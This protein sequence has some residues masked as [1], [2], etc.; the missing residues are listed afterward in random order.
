M[1]DPI[2]TLLD[3]A[4]W[5]AESTPAAEHVE[6][7]SEPEP[8][9]EE[10]EEVEAGP[11]Q[12]EGE[13]AEDED[14]E[15]GEDESEEEGDESEPEAEDVV[16]EG[17]PEVQAFLSKYGND[18]QKA[19]KG[20]AELSRLLG[21]QGRDLSRAQTENEQLRAAL[22]ESQA[23]HA[24]LGMPLNEQQREWVEGAAASPNPA[25]FVQ[26][27]VNEG[28]FDLARAVCREWAVA[29]PYDAL[30]VGQWVNARQDE[31]YRAANQAPQATTDQ[32][33]AALD[34]AM[35]EMRPFYG[36]MTHVIAQ[37]GD[38]HPLVQQSRSPDAEEAMAGMI[39]LYEIARA[40]TATIE[41]AQDE[42]KKKRRREA[43]DERARGQ[44]SSATNS[45]SHAETPRARVLMPGLTQEALDTEFATQSGR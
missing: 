11:E 39:G 18:P 19:L 40:S 32:I 35:P 5:A 25:A 1:P 33:I 37:L 45:P 7:A 12:D 43:D 16:A 22:M 24:G 10:G 4:E 15:E 36:Q 13:P 26:Q 30:Q 23:V 17:D 27:A 28:E 3:E 9:A 42:A 2:N 6:P 34:E 41:G 38:G 21:R 8:E 20:A 14:E 44:V 31:M 29:S